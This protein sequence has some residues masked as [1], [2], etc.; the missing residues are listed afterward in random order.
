MRDLLELFSI[1]YVMFRE[2]LKK[3]KFPQRGG[4]VQAH[5]TLK[6]KPKMAYS[7]DAFMTD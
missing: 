1:D 2:A 3:S 5:S 6:N 7:R 4:G